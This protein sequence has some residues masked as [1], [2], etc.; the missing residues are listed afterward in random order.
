MSCPSARAAA[1]PFAATFRWMA[2]TMFKSTWPAARDTHQLEISVD[3]ERIQLVTIGG[4]TAGGRGGGT[5]RTRPVR[6]FIA[7]R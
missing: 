3:G 2:N 1:W 7:F 4:A 6:W 5:W